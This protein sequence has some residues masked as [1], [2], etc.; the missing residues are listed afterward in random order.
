MTEIQNVAQ[1]IMKEMLKYSRLVHEEFEAA[2]EDVS[3]VLVDDLKR[4]SPEETGSYKKGWRKKKTS[5]G[6]IVHN[7]TDY[8]L[9]HLLE[10][11]HARKG[12]GRPVPA[13]VHIRPN[14][15]KA[16]REFVKRTKKAIKP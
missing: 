5:K 15:E 14:E 9:T 2:K 4:D 16:I 8:Q 12:G 10:Y 13:K 6:W 1:E 7:K 3:N 11:N